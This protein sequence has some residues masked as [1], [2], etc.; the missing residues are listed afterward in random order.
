[1]WDSIKY[2]KAKEFACQ[3]CGEEDIDFDLVERIDELRGLYGLP[4]K[5][6]SGYR[7]PDHPLSVAR[8]TDSVSS[9]TRGRAADIA[10]RSSR[11]RYMLLELIFKHQLFKRIG[12][13]KANQ[14][15]HID[16]D[17]KEKSS[18]VVWIY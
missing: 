8:P 18:E 5:I 15:I 16:V 10:A 12:I 6:T 11:E 3:H 2:F 13:N 9:H 4:I 7:C 1:M 17:D 14:F